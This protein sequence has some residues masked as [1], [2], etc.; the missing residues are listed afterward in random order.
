[1][2]SILIFSLQGIVQDESNI[3]DHETWDTLLIFLLSINDVLL[4]PP[5]ETNEIGTELCERIVS[6]LFEI[7]LIACARS[8]STASFWKTFQHLCR[9]WRH[10]MP[11][12]EQWNRINLALTQRVIQITAPSTAEVQTPIQTPNRSFLQ[13][14]VDELSDE[15]LKQ[16]W[17]RFL[18]LI[19]NPVELCFPE[20]ISKTDKFYHSACA[21]ENVVDPRQ[22]PCLQNLPNIFHKAMKGVANLVDTFLG[23]CDCTDIDVHKSNT[24]IANILKE[25]P[26]V[27]STPPEKR[28][29]LPSLSKSS[30]IVHNIANISGSGK[31]QKAEKP[32]AIVSPQSPIVVALIPF[33]S[34]FILSP[35]RPKSTSILDILGDW[36]FSAALIGFE[37]LKEQSEVGSELQRSGSSTSFTSDNSI[38]KASLASDRVVIE[39]TPMFTSESFQAG[40]AEAIGALC[41]LF[42][43]KRAD[44]EISKMLSKQSHPSFQKVCLL[45]ND[46]VD[47]TFLFTFCR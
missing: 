46:R 42:C 17:F 38:R 36:L 29:N 39:T 11:L 40:Q 22:H 10:R 20:I 24:S 3:M 7:W 34:S 35:N 26:P 18:H 16:T 21:S 30:K 14:I 25:S 45:R 23:I 12:I 44:E 47:F 15:A 31:A 28:P 2:I 5:V 19:G 6:V 33:Q 41:R 37:T 27:P 4:A 8:F 1:M 32:Q 9:G 13:Q 43:S